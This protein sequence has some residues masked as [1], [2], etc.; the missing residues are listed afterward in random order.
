MVLGGYGT[1]QGLQ[2]V[3]IIALKDQDD[4][5]SPLKPADLPLKMSG[6]VAN[7]V[8]NKV[9]ACGGHGVSECFAYD[10]DLGK[11][12]FAIALPKSRYGAVGFMHRNGKAW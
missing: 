1:S 8:D 6:L 2:D 11:W 10:F 3:E 9:V 4:E 7:L 5:N 12:E